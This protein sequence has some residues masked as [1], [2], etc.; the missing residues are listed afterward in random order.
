MKRKLASV[1]L[2]KDIKPIDGADKIEKAKVEGY[3]VIVP[4]NMYSENEKVVFFE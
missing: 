3:N 2:I 1:Q 4:K